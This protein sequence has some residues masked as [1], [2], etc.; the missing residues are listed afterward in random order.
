MLIN[1]CA[2]Q[3]LRPG[4]ITC[5]KRG[6]RESKLNL[7]QELIC[8]EKTFEAVSL[9]PVRI[10]DNHSRRPLRAEPLKPFRVLLDVVLHRDE[11][12]VD[13]VTDLRIRI[14]LGIQPGASPSH[15]SRAE[16]KKQGLVLF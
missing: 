1:N 2:K 4:E 6:L 5:C 8:G 12:L 3:R 9:R 7:G 11:V 14:Y 10:R 13:E 15:R 16:I